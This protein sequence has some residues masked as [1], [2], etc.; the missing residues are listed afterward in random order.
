MTQTVQALDRGLSILD[1]LA[2]HPQGEASLSELTGFLEVD[3]SAVFRMLKTLEGRNLVI[4]DEVAN[5][6]RLGAGVHRLAAAGEQHTPLFEIAAPHL[7]RINLATREDTHLAIRS[8]NS[9]VFLSR[10]G[11]REIIGVNTHVGRREPLYCTAIGRA[12]LANLPEI[13]MRHVLDTTELVR[14][15]PKTLVKKS[16][17]L[18]ELALIRAQGHAIDDEERKAGVYCIASPVFNRRREVIASIGISGL[19]E[20][21]QPNLPAFVALIRACAQEMSASLGLVEVSPQKAARSA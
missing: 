15:T 1:Y 20:R 6:Y 14:L 11:S 13:E 5:I 19:K 3:K 9:V 21:M 10:Q 16:A 4:F 17:L 2:D 18:R 7:R 8:E 12:L